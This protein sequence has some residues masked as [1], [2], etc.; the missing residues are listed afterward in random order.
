VPALELDDGAGI[1]AEVAQQPPQTFGA[2]HV[3]VGDDEDAV[4]DA[5]SSS[6]ARELLRIGE[7]MS[8]SRSS[9][10]RKV[11]VDVEEAR[12]RNVTF[13]VQLPA[14]LGLPEL[15][16]AVDELVAQGYQLP[17]EGGSGTDAGWIT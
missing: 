17:P 2:T 6:C 12:T 15:P 10:R 5:R 3:A 13:E 16:A 7:R 1:V 14:A 4:T 8:A 11:P 9:G